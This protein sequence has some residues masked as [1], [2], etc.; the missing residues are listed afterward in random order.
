M[1]CFKIRAVSRVLAQVPSGYMLTDVFLQLDR[2]MNRNLF[3]PNPKEGEDRMKLA[4]IEACKCK[5][6][7][8]ALRALWRSSPSSY[9]DRMQDLKA[10][11]Q[12]SP[13]KPG[14]G[15]D[16]DEPAGG[17]LSDD[18]AGNEHEGDDSEQGEGEESERGEGEESERG[19]GEE[20]E[21]EGHD[22]ES[23]HGDGVPA[24]DGESEH[25]SLSAKTLELP[26]N[27]SSPEMVSSS[28]ESAESESGVVGDSQVSDGWL[29]RAYMAG[30]AM[31]AQYLF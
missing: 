6:L 26:G 3:Q 13:T 27:G 19:E 4:G 10:T 15:S 12:A 21:C 14:T 24:D 25:G 20:S 17:D 18:G 23:G 22:P 5:K 9:C 31:D 16:D 8:G 11:L 30:N 1:Y 2:K 28:Q 7:I 29:G